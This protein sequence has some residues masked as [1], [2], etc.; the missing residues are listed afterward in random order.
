MSNTRNLIKEFFDAYRDENEDD[1]Q[2]LKEHAL[3]D[4]KFREGL[5]H[6]IKVE[7]LPEISYENISKFSIY[8][9]EN[10]EEPVLFISTPL[11]IAELLSKF[12]V[13]VNFLDNDIFFRQY[14]SRNFDDIYDN[15]DLDIYI[16][17]ELKKK[18]NTNIIKQ[19][20]Y[21]R[22]GLLTKMMSSPKL[23]RPSSPKFSPIEKP[24]PR[25]ASPRKT[26]P[27]PRVITSPKKSTSPRVITSTKISKSPS[28]RVITSPTK[29]S[30]S[31]PTKKSIS[32]RVITSPSPRVI[33]SPA[34]KSP[35][36]KPSSPTKESPTKKT[37]RPKRELSS[38]NKFMQEEIPKMHQNF[39]NLTH[40]QIFKNTAEKW[41]N[42][43][44]NPKNQK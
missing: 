35:T 19:A 13:T 17:D 12:T 14:I 4:K 33:T 20:Q 42:S 6:Y 34:K 28:P 21:Y 40:K 27:S 5:E 32:S 37:T 10:Y 31:S 41:A 26:P 3:S 15:E 24:S 16:I 38:Y 43:L 23:T 9:W 29:K 44:Q 11:E 25:V 30:P 18:H 2:R 7:A 1:I 8:L 36:K 39:P 22:F